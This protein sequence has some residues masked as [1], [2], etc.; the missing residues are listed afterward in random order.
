MYSGIIPITCDPLLP[1]LCTL[2]TKS[3]KAHACDTACYDNNDVLCFKLATLYHQVCNRGTRD[4]WNN[5]ARAN[6]TA[7][8]VM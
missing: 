2:Q 1:S 3:S 5:R 8:P 6:Q 7:A 4:L